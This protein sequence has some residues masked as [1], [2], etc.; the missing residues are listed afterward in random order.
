L[1]IVTYTPTQGDISVSGKLKTINSSFKGTKKYLYV[2]GFAG[3]SISAS[4]NFTPSG[5]VSQPTFNG[6]SE[7]YDVDPKTST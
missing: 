6:T 1:P 2:S 4:G 5:N 7:T 3:G